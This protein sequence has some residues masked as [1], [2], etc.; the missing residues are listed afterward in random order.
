MDRRS[1]W[2][3]RAGRCR[4]R[5]GTCDKL[6]RASQVRHVVEQESEAE[7]GDRQVQH[8]PIRSDALK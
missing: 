7:T 5:S 2:Q 3:K 1:C 4:I 8:D 6:G